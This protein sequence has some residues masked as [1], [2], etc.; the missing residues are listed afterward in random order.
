VRPGQ[1]NHLPAL[2]G[3]QGTSRPPRRPTSVCSH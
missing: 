2:P 1:H 3:H